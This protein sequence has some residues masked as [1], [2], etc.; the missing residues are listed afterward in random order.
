MELFKLFGSIVVDNSKADESIKKTDDKAKGLGST[1]LGGVKSAGKFALGIGTAVAGAAVAAGAALVKVA[2]DTREYRTAMGKLDTAFTTAGFTSQQATDT[3]KSLQAVL[4]DTDQAVEASNNLAQ[5]CDS[6]EELQKWT[7]ISTGVFATFGD[8]LPVE[9]LAE[10]ANETAK[11]GTVTGSLADAL[12]WVGVSEDDFNASLA[13]CS[14]EQERS[15]LITDT[16]NG[17]YSDASEQYQ[18][19]NKDV[20]DAN[21]AQEKLNGTMADI[22]A[23]VEP[24]LTT[25]KLGFA[26]LLEGLIPVAEVIATAVIPA[27]MSFVEMVI[28]IVSEAIT[29]F[30]PIVQD[31]VDAVSSLFSGLAESASGSGITFS[32]VM[33]TIQ[34][35]FSGAMTVLQTIWDTIGL[36]LFDLW[37]SNIGVV[38][39]YFGEKMPEIQAAVSTAFSDI[40]TIW[41]NNLKPCLQAIG[42]FINNV[43]APAFKFV[44]QNIIAPVIDAVFR[45]IGE[46]WNNS[47]KP[48]FT[49]I[50]D[51]IK[52]VFTGNFSGAFKNI[53]NIVKGIW[54]GIIDIIKVPINGVIGIINK[55]IGGLNKLKI[56]DWVPLVGGKGIDIPEI[57]LLAK[58]GTSLS[59][60]KAIV[61][62]AGPEMIDLPRGATVTPLTDGKGNVLGNDQMTELLTLILA[63]LKALRSNLYDTIVNA[64]VNGVAIDWSDREL[65]RLVRKYA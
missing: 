4:G 5:L 22:G 47:L 54:N 40:K 52:N 48:I 6:Q 17:L 32:D 56:P 34:T 59:A 9:A 39:D 13:N 51:F 61:G 35:L 10:A 28:P 7:T 63:E 36:P 27:F 62:D 33:N 60:G 37:Q 41:E 58:G 50:I 65:A 45:G 55:F 21:A 44:F 64:L 25:A 3:Y 46:L 30:M 20:M 18:Q 16:L 49:N 53:I 38:A 26:S 57:P 31:V 2:E 42:D 15:A 1:F 14:T 19:T 8:G 43:L 11:V 23:A 29:T 12:N 24:I